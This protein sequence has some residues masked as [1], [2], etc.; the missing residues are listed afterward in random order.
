MSNKS[1]AIGCVNPFNYM[2]SKVKSTRKSN[3]KF[4]FKVEN[5]LKPNY[6]GQDGRWNKHEQQLFIEGLELYGKNWKKVQNHVGTRSTTQIRSHAQKY[7]AKLSKDVINIDNK[8][9]HKENEINAKTQA[10]TPVDSSLQ[11]SI[12]DKNSM[13]LY[14]F[15]KEVQEID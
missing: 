13:S 5:K 8:I 7:F 14:M 1:V 2:T 9:N 3:A 10:S 6:E 12:D 15:R 11:Y 4:A